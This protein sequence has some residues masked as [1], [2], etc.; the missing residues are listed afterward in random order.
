[1]EFDRRAWTVF[2]L[3]GW[4]VVLAV[5]LERRL[6]LAGGIIMLAWMLAQQYRFY[7][8]VAAWKRAATVEYEARPGHV[9]TEEPVATSIAVSL[10]GPL[11]VG[12]TITR[13]SFAGEHVGTAD[14]TLELEPGKTAAKAEIPVSFPVA[15]HFATGNLAAELTDGTGLFRQTVPLDVEPP[16]VRVA[17]RAPRN[18]HVG[19]GGDRMAAE[20]GEHPTGRVGTGLT[21]EEVR[22]YV[23]GDSARRIDWKATAR[24]NHPHIREFEAETDR[25]TLLFVDRRARLAVGPEGETALDYAREVAVAVLDSAR[26]LGDPL[27]YVAVGDD[28]LTDRILPEADPSTYTG[29][30]T[31]VEHLEP[32][33]DPT[34]PGHRD[35]TPPAVA[36]QKA[37]ALADGGSAFAE[38]L[39]PFFARADSYVTRLEGDPLYQG[40]KT[41]LQRVQGSVWSIVVTDDA[42]PARLIETVKLARQRGNHVLVFVLPRALFEGEAL[43]DVDSAYEDYLAFEEFRRDLARLDRVSAFEVA[44]GQRLGAILEARRAERGVGSG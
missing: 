24:F 37:A 14:A 32:T 41:T 36:R 10:D 44:P 6:L 17:A 21:P 16:R 4:L 18:I 29:I 23:P 20:F 35:V 34:A 9:M 1:M 22:E 13:G 7:R 19:Q 38:T 12:A 40:V 42:N 5:I 25:R 3:G 26:E 43:A 27:G 31:Q 30:R 33:P 28:G 11:G 2:A 15:G 39:R 8:R